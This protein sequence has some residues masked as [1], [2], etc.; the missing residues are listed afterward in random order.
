ML[1]GNY[2]PFL[3]SQWISLR[4]KGSIIAS[5]MIEVSCANWFKLISIIMQVLANSLR[6]FLR[7]PSTEEASFWV[8]SL[9]MK[10]WLGIVECYNHILIQRTC[11]QSNNICSVCRHHQPI[12]SDGKSRKCHCCWG[13]SLLRDF[14]WYNPLF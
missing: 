6:Y 13:I 9:K 8:T 2:I 11:A 4:N 10:M 3:G 7:R 1:L 14:R 12:R 5:C